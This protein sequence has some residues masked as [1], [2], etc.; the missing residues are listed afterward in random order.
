MN[1][2]C[3]EE[4]F[5]ILFGMENGFTMF[6]NRCIADVV[7]NILLLCFCIV[8]LPFRL[9]KAVFTTSWWGY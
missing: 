1:P 6:G 4:F 7:G 3:W 9:I 8:L 2:N 5:E